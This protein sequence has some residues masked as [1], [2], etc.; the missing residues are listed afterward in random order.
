VNGDISNALWSKTTDTSNRSSNDT[1][2]F[3]QIDCKTFVLGQEAI[4][5]SRVV[6]VT[7]NN[8]QLVSNNIAY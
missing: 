2:M 4:K 5:F 3:M 7:C 6:S 1:M 8:I